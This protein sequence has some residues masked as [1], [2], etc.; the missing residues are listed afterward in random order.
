MF[1]M[2]RRWLGT[3]IDELYR[4]PQCAPPLSHLK[5]VP[6]HTITVRVSQNIHPDVAGIYG[7][8]LGI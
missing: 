2:D 5:V 3:P 8:V 4:M 1:S 7:S 6:N